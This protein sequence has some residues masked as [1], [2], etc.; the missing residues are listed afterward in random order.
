MIFLETCYNKNNGGIKMKKTNGRYKL[1]FCDDQTKLFISCNINTGEILPP[2]FSNKGMDLPILDQYL[3]QTFENEQQLRC[4][5]KSLGYII[6]E[7]YKP[8]IAYQSQG[9]T[10][11]LEIIYQE[12][13]LIQM[14][15]ICQK[16][17]ERYKNRLEEKKSNQELRRIISKGISE[18][19]AWIQFYKKMKSNIQSEEFHH[20][21]MKYPLLG[22]RVLWQIQNYLDQTE[23]SEYYLRDTFTSYKPIR[24]MIV[25]MKKYQET[26]GEFAPKSELQ[27][28]CNCFSES[29]LLYIEKHPN[30]ERMTDEEK[31]QLLSSFLSRKSNQSQTPIS[32]QKIKE[33]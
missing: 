13:T 12:S 16:Y 21:I 17:K 2:T 6:P 4:H 33:N 30:Y 25:M 20:Y 5:L 8:K 27:S 1:V 31:I 7:Y 28:L 3:A 11:L 10:R 23:R 18:E 32:Y 15:I 14:A 22:N 24:G 19:P 26:F 9:H 29:E